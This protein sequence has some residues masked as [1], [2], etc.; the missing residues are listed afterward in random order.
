MHPQAVHFSRPLAV[1]ATMVLATGVPMATIGL[2]RLILMVLARIVFIFAATV[3]PVPVIIIDILVV[4]SA[5][6]LPH[7]ALIF[8]SYLMRKMRMWR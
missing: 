3:R 6:L 4:L 1:L 8:R 7:L 5:V 2:V